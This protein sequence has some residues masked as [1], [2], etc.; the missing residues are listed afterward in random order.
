MNYNDDASTEVN[1][2]I[3][4]VTPLTGHTD[5]DS[6]YLVEDYP[7][8]RRLRCQ[9]RY[10]IETAIKGS[11][12]GQQRFVSQT[13]DPR[14]EGTV[15]NKPHP[16]TYAQIAVMYLDGKGHVHWHG[17][18]FWI[19]GPEDVRTREMGIYDAFTDDQRKLYDG[20]LR[21]ARKASPNSW[22]D[23]EANVARLAAYITETGELPELQNKVWKQ[24]ARLTSL[25]DPAAYA[26]AARATIPVRN[27]DGKPFVCSK[28]LDPVRVDS[29][30][31]EHVHLNGQPLCPVFD[32]RAPITDIYRGRPTDA[33]LIRE[34]LGNTE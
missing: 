26:A 11:A 4:R 27:A 29:H 7:Y 31:G 22:A 1:W 2:T 12:K 18:P 28:C 19:D 25:S 15:W 23:W 13:T 21:L 16:S 8:G 33:E 14:R 34:A 9:I 5:A 10:W 6:A 30:T 20:M 24:G 32:G 17:I 3:P